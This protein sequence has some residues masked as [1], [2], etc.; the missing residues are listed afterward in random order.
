M[1]ATQRDTH[2][3]LAATGNDAANARTGLVGIGQAVAQ[4]LLAHGLSTDE[5]PRAERAPRP[6]LEQA[7]AGTLPPRASQQWAA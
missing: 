4:V 6:E 3:H 2:D 7:L 5:S 1:I